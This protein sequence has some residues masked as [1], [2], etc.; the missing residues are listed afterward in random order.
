MDGRRENMVLR[1]RGNIH[2]SEN[3]NML[4]FCYGSKGEGGDFPSYFG[5][6]VGS[7]G[8]ERLQDRGR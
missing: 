1:V 2:F 5:N 7:C 6:G 8:L 4:R 3:L